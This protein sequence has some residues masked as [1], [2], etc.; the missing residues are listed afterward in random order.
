MENYWLVSSISLWQINKT[1]SEVMTLG[2]HGKIM[3]CINF[4][5]IAK[6]DQY[7]YFLRWATVTT[8]KENA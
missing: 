5:G 8:I 7:N 6:S 3:V 4:P 2:K 1:V